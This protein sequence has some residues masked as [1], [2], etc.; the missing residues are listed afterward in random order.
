MANYLSE[1][2]KQTIL[3]LL[4]LKYSQRE[5][6]RQ[7]GIRRE[8]ISKYGKIEGIIPA[9]EP[10]PASKVPPGSPASRS[11]SA[12]Y[13]K[14]I[15]AA[16]SLG[17]N[18]KR[19]YH[20]LKAEGFPGKY[21]SVKRF[22]KK[23]KRLKP[24]VCARIEVPPGK[25]AQVD[26]G[27]GASTFNPAT[28]K[29]R[30]PN[31]FRMVLSF[32]RHSYE[33]VI[34]KQDVESFIRAHENA[35]RF[36]GGVPEVM[37]LDNLKAGVIDACFYDPTINP[38][39]QAFAK[40]Y[41]FEVLPCK[42]RTPEHKGKVE[43][44]INYA[45]NAVKGKTFESLDGQNDY[46]KEWNKNIAS[47]RIHGT[48]KEQVIKRFNE[49]ERTALRPLPDEPFRMFKIGIR[50]VHVDGHIEV[51]G[52]Y[53]SVPCE[54][55]GEEVT[56]HRDTK[57]IRV[58]DKQGKEIAVH[59]RQ[60]KGCFRTYDEH[61]PEHKRWSQLRMEKRFREQA[62]HLGEEVSKWTEK[63]FE[64]RGVL[65]FRV[66]QGMISLTKKYS[67][68]HINYAC[69]QALKLQ[70]FRYHVLKSLCEKIPTKEERLRQEDEIIRPLCEYAI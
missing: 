59:M 35:F 47:L 30:K 3:A 17:V 19:I 38:V 28:N 58:Y 18:A 24:D 7:T 67:S 42:V 39:Y 16:L 27:K 62:A 14:Q 40:H 37:M 10:K 70:S 32:S 11:L 6:Q 21:W 5:I 26:F 29:Y 64:E 2:E 50:R 34:W 61:L 8:T 22:V 4:R 65:A 69:G 23:L 41:G 20:D 68:G 12:P 51:D 56:I 31:L 45:Q 1:N 46:L 60:H 48:V 53:Y 36:F 44:G 43:S 13:Q 25:E 15:E 52:A 54:Y 49:R 63:I 57:L 66:L 33:E 9:G 55:L